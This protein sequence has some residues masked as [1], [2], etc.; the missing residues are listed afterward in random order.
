MGGL[1]SYIVPNKLASADYAAGTRRVL[2][3]H[4][5]LLSLRDYSHVP[6]FPVAVYPIVYVASRERPD[7]TAGQVVYEKMRTTDSGAIECELAHPLPYDRFSCR[8]ES[9]WEI[10]NPSG[11]DALIER[12]REFPRLGE[13]A[14]VHGAATVAEAYEIKELIREAK[15]NDDGAVQFVNSGTIDR[16]ESLWGRKPCR[17]LGA[18][19][20]RPVIARSKQRAFRASDCCKQKRQK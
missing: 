16:Y 9:P 7:V 12:L 14:N 20:M 4:N 13:V 1:S 3:I 18:T 6:V 17:Y 8:P 2:T 15:S 11:D 5:R 19:F 10:F